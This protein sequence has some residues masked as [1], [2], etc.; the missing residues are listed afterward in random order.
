MFVQPLEFGRGKDKKK[1]KKSLSTRNRRLIK[2]AVLATT[3]GLGAGGAVLA[4]KGLRE[5]IKSK[6]VDKLIVG[7]DRLANTLTNINIRKVNTMKDFTRGKTKYISK[8]TRRIAAKVN[9]FEEKGLR[10]IVDA[11][12]RNRRLAL[13]SGAALGVAL[14]AGSIRDEQQR[15]KKNKFGR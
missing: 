10:K 13:G 6:S 11:D 14:N 4:T 9:K 15:S 2:G 5:G 3:V 8:A 12:N 1:R 7:R